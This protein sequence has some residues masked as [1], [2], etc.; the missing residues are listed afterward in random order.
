MSSPNRLALKRRASTMVAP[1]AMAG[2][3]PPMIAFEWNSGIDM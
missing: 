3:K 2:E 1:T